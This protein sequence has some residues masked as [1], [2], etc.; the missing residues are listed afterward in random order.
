[1]I[2]SNREEL[3]SPSFLM[4]GYPLVDAGMRELLATGWMHNQMRVVTASFLVKFL[5]LPWPWGVKYF[6]DSQIDADLEEDV[7]G[8][9]FT[10]GCLPDGIPFDAINDPEEEGPKLDPEGHYVRRYSASEFV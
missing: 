8:W 1:M 9:Q 7:L 2:D 10:S 3:I 5:M 6:W 4:T